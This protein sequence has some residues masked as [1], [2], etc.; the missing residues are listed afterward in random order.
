ML[1][2]RTPWA[3]D[4]GVS[5]P[6]KCLE[7]AVEADPASPRNAFSIVSVRCNDR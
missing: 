3:I 1:P 4:G 7:L 5:M 2:R 6:Q